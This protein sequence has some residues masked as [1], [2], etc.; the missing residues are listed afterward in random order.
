M[1]TDVTV[2][3][4]LQVPGPFL[5]GTW[6]TLKRQRKYGPRALAYYTT[7]VQL[8]IQPMFCLVLEC[9]RVSVR[10]FVPKAESR[11]LGILAAILSKNIFK[12]TNY[13]TIILP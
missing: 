11:M 4:L 7:V 1:S 13:F 6:N 5:S 2:C 3:K 12:N 8:Q 10:L 9:F